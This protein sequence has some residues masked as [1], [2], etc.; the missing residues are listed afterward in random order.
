MFG[1][2]LN[3]LIVILLLMVIFVKPKDIPSVINAIAKLWKKT[4]AFIE[5]IRTQIHNI[6]TEI[7][8]TKT[9]TYESFHEQ[10]EKLRKQIKDEEK[11]IDFFDDDY[12]RITPKL[13]FDKPK[14]KKKWQR[15]N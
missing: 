11:E 10:I 6:T 3:E 15:N 12:E 13:Q 4:K 1:I 2:S 5:E 7:D 14:R 8:E 9:E